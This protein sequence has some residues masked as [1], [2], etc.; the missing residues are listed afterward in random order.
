M[1]QEVAEKLPPGQQLSI[2]VLDVNLAGELE[3]V[4]RTADELRVLRNVTWPMIEFEY[5][6]SDNGRLLTGR[7]EAGD[8]GTLRFSGVLS[9]ENN[10]GFSDSHVGARG[11]LRRRE[12]TGAA[13]QGRR[14]ELPV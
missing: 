11:H 13:R 5:Q 7:I 14:P 1:L 8:G 3:W 6:L 10:G 12:R 2:K 4:R 9:L